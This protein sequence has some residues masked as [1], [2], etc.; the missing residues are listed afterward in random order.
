MKFVALLE[1]APDQEKIKAGHPAHREY[2]RRFLE[3]GQRRAAGPFADGA[4][5]LWVL[6][7]ETAA[8]VENIVRGD[9][10]VAAGVLVKWR[11]RPLAY[12][13]AQEVRAR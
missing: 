2:L 3:N 10:F 6:D 11:V 12:W 8:A 4:G 13:L 7:A 5:T 1:Y 9:P